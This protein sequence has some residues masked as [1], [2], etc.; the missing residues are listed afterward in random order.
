MSSLESFVVAIST[1]P[2]GSPYLALWVLILTT[3]FIPVAPPEEVITLLAGACLGTGLLNTW[4]TAAAT[5]TGIIVVNS[6]QYGLGRLVLLP[7][8]RTN[9]GKRILSTAYL[10]KG[11][12]LMEQRGVLAIIMCRFMFG[13]RTPV[14]LSAGFLRFRYL[15]FLAIDSV[16]V[17]SHAG[18]FLALGYFF[19]K[20]IDSLITVLTHSALV[21]T[22]L[23]A[24]AICL[25]FG[26]RRLRRSPNS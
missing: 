4:H 9:L 8:A 20:Q 10:S 7:L 16:M 26:L 22:L 19:H 23:I 1:S 12:Q 14:Y 11:E 21:S 6:F 15:R 25:V 2:L 18:L 13:T 5:I 24:A 3:S 17:I